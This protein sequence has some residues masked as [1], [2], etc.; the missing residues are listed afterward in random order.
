MIHKEG[1]PFLVYVLVTMLLLIIFS[2]LLLSKLIWIFLSIFFIVFYIFLIL[3]FRNPKRNFY[4]IQAKN[5]NEEII[6][7]P[8]DGKILSIQ[9]IFENEFLK[10]NC[11]CISIF[12]SIFNVH[13]NRF[14]VSGKIVYVKYHP[15]KYRIAFF[16]KSSS[17]NEH[18]TTVVKTNKGENILFR[19]IAGFLARRII[20]Y[21][22]ENSIVKKG[23]EFGFIKFGSRVDIFLPLHSI[24]LVK[25]GEKVTGG[26]TKISIVPHFNK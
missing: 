11:I 19:Q 3:F 22:R 8:A 1:N 23:D 7:S 18:T 6:I 12:M 20:L 16:P 21:A 26:E 25:K 13:V 4:E 15:G 14:P 2:F 10:K 5:Y 24:I 17:Q 9:E